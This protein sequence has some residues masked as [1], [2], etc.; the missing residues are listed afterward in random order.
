[1]VGKEPKDIVF[2]AV[3]A[4]VGF[5][6]LFIREGRKNGWAGMR[7]KLS[8]L[9]AQDV[10]IV[11]VLFVIIVV[12][13]VAKRPYE[14]WRDE[15]SSVE[16]AQKLI[17][18]DRTEISVC[19]AE[20]KAGNDKT[21]LLGR[22]VSAQQT[23]IAK[24]QSTSATQQSTFDTCVSTLAKVNVPIAPSHQMLWLNEMAGSTAKHSKRMIVITNV[25]ISPVR[26]YL[27]CD[28]PLKAVTVQPL[29][30]GVSS[31]GTQPLSSGSP[32]IA[33][34]TWL[35]GVTFP[36]WSPTDPLLLQL[37]YDSED[38]GECVIRL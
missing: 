29:G 30:G 15:R 34:K 19:K 12:F 23:L 9:A 11:L 26:L 32:F 5:I 4:L 35:V 28:S 6:L 13:H 16:E 7:K 25:A 1:M 22:Q 21:E 3:V 18:N 37:D 33:P 8:A 20:S 38:V 2:S 27:T 10:L 24:Q 17:A 14:M 31:G 36:A